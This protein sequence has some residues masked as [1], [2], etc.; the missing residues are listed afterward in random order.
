M[1]IFDQYKQWVKD[2]AP[3]YHDYDPRGD[4]MYWRIDGQDYGPISV[5]DIPKVFRRIM[6]D[7]NLVTYPWEKINNEALSNH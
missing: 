5:E 1:S 4:G 2:N 6:A 7:P 3:K